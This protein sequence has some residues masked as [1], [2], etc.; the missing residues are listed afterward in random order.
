MAP[1]GESIEEAGQ[2]IW[3][4]LI[5][6]ELTSGFDL[7]PELVKERTTTLTAGEMGLEAGGISLGERSLEVLGGEFEE[8]SA[9][10][11]PIP[12]MAAAAAV[13]SSGHVVRYSSS[14]L[15]TLLRAR[16]SNTR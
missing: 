9:G 1:A 15:R 16:C 7:I 11:T 2:G 8:L 4:D 6:G 5:L 10:Q 3:L 13:V 14:W 12:I